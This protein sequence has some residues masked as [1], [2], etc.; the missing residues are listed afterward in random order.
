MHGGDITCEITGR[1]R[2][3]DVDG[4]GLEVPC[5][6]T[7]LGKLRNCLSYYLWRRL[8]TARTS[9][10]PF[11]RL[12]QSHNTHKRFLKMPRTINVQFLEMEL[13]V[14]K[15]T[16]ATTV[17]NEFSKCHWRWQ[18]CPFPRIVFF[19]PLRS[20]DSPQRLLK[21]PRRL[22]KMSCGGRRCYFLE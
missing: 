11:N 20:Q 16:T 17:T 6:H 1:R 15:A 7:S 18:L 2:R 5:N 4:K 10:L 12:L 3:S 19:W 21:M 22:L 9:C 14:I 8:Q 13:A